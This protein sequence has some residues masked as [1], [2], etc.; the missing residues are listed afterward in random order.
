[1]LLFILIFLDGMIIL[2]I[3]WENNNAHD[4]EIV[5]YHLEDICQ[6]LN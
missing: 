1:M 6:K 2:F 5:D 4:V 3:E